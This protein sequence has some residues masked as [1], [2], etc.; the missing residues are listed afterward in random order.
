MVESAQKELTEAQ[1][2]AIRRREYYTRRVK[3][4]FEPLS[5]LRDESTESRGS[6][7]PISA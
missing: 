5:K 4:N 7:P 3:A 2:R 1:I 6:T